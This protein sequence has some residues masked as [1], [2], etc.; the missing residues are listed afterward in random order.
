MNNPEGFEVVLPPREAANQLG[1][2]PSTLRRLA[3]VYTDVYG[4][5]ALAWSDGGKGSGSRL[6]TG[7][8][9]RRTRAARDLVE[10]GR[11]SSFELALRT[12]KDAPEGVLMLAPVEVDNPGEVAALRE[13]VAA[14]RKAL[15]EVREEVAAMKA[16]PPPAE[17]ERA[18]EPS[19]TATP[20]GQAEP[21]R[22]STSADSDTAA[23]RPGDGT[24]AS[25]GLLVR[26]ARW[27]ERRLRR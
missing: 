1:V 25:D 15:E 16:L 24:D 7:K 13:E 10:S 12:L 9:L 20:E 18:E 8:A 14:L 17:P 22:P 6:W 4:Q 26:A 23:E 3:T 11:A 27:L 2:A 21:E 5:D 19:Q